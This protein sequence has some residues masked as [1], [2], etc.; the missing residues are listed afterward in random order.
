MAYRGCVVSNVCSQKMFISCMTWH[1]QVIICKNEG[2]KRWISYNFVIQWSFVLTQNFPHFVQLRKIFKLTLSPLFWVNLHLAWM[3]HILKLTRKGCCWS[4]KEK[5]LSTVDTK[6]I[7]A[8]RFCLKVLH[9]CENFGRI[10]KG[11]KANSLAF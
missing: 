6:K 8:K 9:H 4:E 5:Q 1:H 7:W 11:Q 2:K 10:R 3:V